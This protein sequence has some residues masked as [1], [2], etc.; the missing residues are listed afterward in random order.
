MPK[1]LLS[2]DDHIQDTIDA[3]CQTRSGRFQKVSSDTERA[4][5]VISSSCASVA[6]AFAATGFRWSKSALSLSRRLG[7]FTHIVSFQ[8]DGTNSSGS[9]VGIAIHAQT[10]CTELAKWR[11]SNGVTTGSSIW[12][13]QIGY[14]SPAHEYLKWQLV[15]PITRQAEIASMVQTIR[16]L[17]IP[18]FDVANSKKSLSTHLVERREITWIPD[19][20]VDTA[21]WLENRPAAE[22][23]IRNHIYS[24]KEMATDFRVFWQM[25]SKNPSPSKP[26]NRLHCLAWLAVKYDLQ[27]NNEA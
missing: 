27:V 10:K 17:A 5:D 8:A 26:T 24:R 25:E 3:R 11:E 1:S 2:L 7:S 4:A 13:T 9:H 21:L 23:L 14:L 19:W 20:A 22:A 16:D 15:D 6:E 18:A 12:I